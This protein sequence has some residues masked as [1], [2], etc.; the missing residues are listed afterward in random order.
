M[1]IVTGGLGQPADSLVTGGFGQSAPSGASGDMAAAAAGV[2]TCTGTL[3]DGS[4]AVVSGGGKRRRRA[5]TV[6]RLSWGNW[7]QPTDIAAVLRGTSSVS[8]TLTASPSS[9]IAAALPVARPSR[10]RRAPA[11]V[12]GWMAARVVVS[13]GAYGALSATA[14]MES[15]ASGAGGVSATV[16][17]AG[18]MAVEA[19]GMAGMRADLGGVAHASAQASGAAV[20]AGIIGAVASLEASASGRSAVAARMSGAGMMACAIAGRAQCV[21]TGETTGQDADEELL[22]TAVMIATL[23]YHYRE[24]A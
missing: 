17:A 1:A 3:T 24:A 19:A 6:E 5:P 12:A 23:L 15:H 21:A 22:D 18:A 2:S 11:R 8:A 9:S 13:S 16:S 4:A 14:A 7:A 20:M 10:A